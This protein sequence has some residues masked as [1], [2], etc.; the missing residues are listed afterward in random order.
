MVDPAEAVLA[1]IWIAIAALVAIGCGGKT[2][3]TGSTG[4]GGSSGGGGTGGVAG[5]SGGTSGSCADSPWRPVEFTVAPS[6]ARYKHVAVANANE[7]TVIIW[8]GLG[9]QQNGSPPKEPV[10]ATGW[11]YGVATG[12]A[13]PIAA[14]S[15]GRSEAR[16]A[17]FGEKMYVSGGIAATA[18]TGTGLA[19]WQAG[20]SWESIQSMPVRTHAVSGAVKETWIVWGGLDEIGNPTNDGYRFSPTSGEWTATSWVG[21]PSPRVWASGVAI[22][23]GMLWLWGGA[24]AN[25]DLD[26]GGIYDVDNDWW[27]PFVAPS[28]VGGRSSAYV[29]WLAG[30]QRVVIWGGA[31]SSGDSL[32]TGWIVDP[33]TNEWAPMSNVGAPPPV[34][35]AGSAVLDGKKLLLFGGFAKQSNGEYGIT[36]EGFV[37]DTEL[38][39]W[40]TVD[41]SCGPSP[42]ELPTVTAIAGQALIWG[43][44]PEGDVGSAPNEDAFVLT[45]AN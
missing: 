38:D 9:R 36:N 33:K 16:A 8:G 6:D 25:S 10:L 18:L 22:G 45:L 7:S 35:N 31:P 30:T 11:K 27:E 32:N 12:I 43:G 39:A 34:V 44:I 17:W 5:G 15:D 4:G 3:N 37:Y 21:A 23:D 1:S 14:A 40:S 20:D 24:S 19:Y 2:D 13:G 26:D 29:A 41:A 42:R 28:E